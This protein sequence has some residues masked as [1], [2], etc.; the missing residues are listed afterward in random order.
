MT[1]A[2]VKPLNASCPQLC[3]PGASCRRELSRLIP[4][5]CGRCVVSCTGHLR[6]LIVA[7]VGGFLCGYLRLRRRPKSVHASWCSS[8]GKT[9][10]KVKPLNATW[11]Q[12]CWTGFASARVKPLNSCVPQSMRVSCTGHLRRLIVAWLAAHGRHASARRRLRVGSVS[13]RERLACKAHIGRGRKSTNR[14][15]KSSADGPRFEPILNA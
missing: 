10:A 8:A 5:C 14:G 2:K 12:L 7:F 1:S 13:P 3:W 11:P 6:R 9:S 4:E 15:S